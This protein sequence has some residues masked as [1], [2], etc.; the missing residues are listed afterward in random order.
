MKTHGK[1]VSNGMDASVGL[2]TALGRHDLLYQTRQR[3][4]QPGRMV[5]NPK[6]KNS[7]RKTV[8]RATQRHQNRSVDPVQIGHKVLSA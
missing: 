4:L 1:L 5:S 3:E 8:F 6:T 2:E 7:G